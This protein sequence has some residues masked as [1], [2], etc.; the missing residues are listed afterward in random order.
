M[1]PQF[2][3]EL[4]ASGGSLEIRADLSLE[5]PCL[6]SSSCMFSFLIDGLGIVTTS[7][8]VGLEGVPIDGTGKPASSKATIVGPTIPYYARLEVETPARQERH[9]RPARIASGGF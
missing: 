8:V 4:S 2:G 6:R 9:R 1:I 5:W 3:D 7:V